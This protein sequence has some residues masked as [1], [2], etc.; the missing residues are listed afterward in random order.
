MKTLTLI[1]TLIMTTTIGFG[2]STKNNL[3]EKTSIISVDQL[4]ADMR[5]LWE[6]HI[7]LTH[8]VVVSVITDQAG[9]DDLVRQMD[10]NLKEMGNTIAAYYGD[11]AGRK[12]S[13]L[14][15][16]NITLAA[17]LMI[18]TR[19]GHD[20]A[21]DKA[22]KKWQANADEIVAFL[23]AT[24]PNWTVSEMK[25][26]IYSQQWYIAQE[27]IAV[28]S[29][30]D[31]GDLSAYNNANLAVLTMADKMSDGIIRQ[32]PERFTEFTHSYGAK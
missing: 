5:K 11:E 14:L 19:R 22:E 8:G 2:Q 27:A 6:D 29:K 13:K 32:F 3:S 4:K 15:Y 1:A 25:A 18:A 21:Y 24:N 31:K 23:N 7:T 9:M 10:Q 20:A 28:K 17:D 12:Y 26:M 30:D 16:S